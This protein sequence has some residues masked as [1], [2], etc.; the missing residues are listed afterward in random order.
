MH[1]WSS[2]QMHL[3]MGLLYIVRAFW[4]I[5][6]CAVILHSFLPLHAFLWIL[7]SLASTLLLEWILAFLRVSEI[8]TFRA[9]GHHLTP[10][11]VSGPSLVLNV[12]LLWLG[13]PCLHYLFSE[14]LSL[15]PSVIYC[16]FLPPL[17]WEHTSI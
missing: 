16:V 6:N 11:G 1:M 4:E 12:Y 14:K 10:V 17:M 9:F 15:M 2:S 13:M 7:C 5:L 3:P 8:Y